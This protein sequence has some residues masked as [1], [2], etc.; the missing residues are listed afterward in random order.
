MVAF[1][2]SLASGSYQIEYEVDGDEV[3]GRA[4]SRLVF[5]RAVT[6]DC[7]ALDFDALLAREDAAAGGEVDAD[8]LRE[9]LDDAAAESERAYAADEAPD[10]DL[11][12]GFDPY[13]GAYTDD[14]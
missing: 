12:A 5:A 1:E 4:V 9:R 14:C 10:Y 2:M 13:V 6:L 7:T 8:E 3:N 11:D